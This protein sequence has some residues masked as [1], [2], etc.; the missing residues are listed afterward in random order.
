[1]LASPTLGSREQRAWGASDEPTLGLGLRS[2]HY[3]HVLEHW[4][5]VG[6]F[7]VL[8]ENYME[9]AGRPL[10]VVEAIAARYPVVMHG[11]ALSIGS[12]DP[13]D[14]AYLDGL[15]GLRDRI[16]ARWVSDHLCWT[17]V[18]GRNTH[19]LL[20]LPMTDETLRHVADRVR[21]V[22]D[23]LGTPLVL[24]NPS[25]YVRFRHDT[26]PEW[27]FL[28]ALVKATDCRLLLD[29]NNVVVNGKNHGFS[30]DTYLRG[31]PMEAVV[32][33]HIAGHTVVG[34][35]AIDTH[36][37]PVP[38]EVWSALAGAWQLGA[39]APIFLE[40]D[41]DIPPFDGVWR[42]LERVRAVLAADGQSDP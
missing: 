22:Q 32:Q 19:D 16:G 24:E 10:H 33:M 8:T 11:V 13:L 26:M 12:T 7:E 27:E 17:G 37:G 23:R 42:E 31:V 15:V 4:P 2:A 6:G 40:W 30:V 36:V 18:H 3:A 29:V 20:P 9:T 14:E 25:T 34:A 38:S 41:T 39:R 1:M 35:H 21:H 28:T 5:D